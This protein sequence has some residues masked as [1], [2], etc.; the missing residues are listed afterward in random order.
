MPV[1]HSFWP[2]FEL[3]WYNRREQQPV[4]S[5]VAF[6]IA[7]F[8]ALVVAFFVALLFVSQYPQVDYK[9]HLSRSPAAGLQSLPH[10]RFKL[11]ATV[12]RTFN[13]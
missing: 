11:D 3:S 2:V 4:M 6:L 1:S 7:F 13:G 5:L 8:V 9:A 12:S 10:D